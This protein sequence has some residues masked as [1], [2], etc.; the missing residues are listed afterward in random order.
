MCV[1]ARMQGWKAGVQP[2]ARTKKVMTLED[3]NINPWVPEC[4]QAEERLRKLLR[5]TL[6]STLS[7]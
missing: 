4:L 6:R 7:D 1:C 3:I 2:P 5:Q